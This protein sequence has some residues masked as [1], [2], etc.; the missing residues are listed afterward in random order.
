MDVPVIKP[1][2]RR[3]CENHVGENHSARAFTFIGSKKQK[4]E[5][6]LQHIA[7]RREQMPRALLFADVQGTTEMMIQVLSSS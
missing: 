4:S 2:N 5:S 7:S 6:Y 3:G 1:Q